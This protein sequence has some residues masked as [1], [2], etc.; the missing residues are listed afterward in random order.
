MKLEIGVLKKKLSECEEDID[1]L[2]VERDEEVKLVY[3][4]RLKLADAW[5]IEFATDAEKVREVARLT[6]KNEEKRSYCEA[7]KETRHANVTIKEQTNVLNQ[8]PL[9]PST[10]S[11]IDIDLDVMTREIKNQ[12][13]LFVDEKLRNLGIK[14]SM[15]TLQKNYE[16]KSSM[17]SQVAKNNSEISET[18][19]KQD[20]FSNEREANVIIHGLTE[21]EGEN[22]ENKIR[23]I[24]KA[25][26]V[27]LKP[28]TMFRLGIKRGDR[29]RPL[30][31]RMQSKEEK[32]TIMS[33]LWKLKYA[34]AKVERVSI[35]HDFTIEERMSIK[36]M[37][38]ESKRRNENESKNGASTNYAW[39]L[40]GNPK[41][42]MQLVKVAIHLQ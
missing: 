20:E 25:I 37:V 14:A 42:G 6:E 30:M 41:C 23:D 18:V 5:N 19:T 39:K 28:V 2:V 16:D 1:D 27:N 32:Y 21:V 26:D 9:I 12:V 40:R 34:R 36:E 8:K 35:T 11:G 4:L 33:K 38:D 17:K 3:E 31:V 7:V 29:S 24:F 13:N 22:D 15:D 10:D